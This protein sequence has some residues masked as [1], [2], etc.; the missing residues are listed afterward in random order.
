MSNLIAIGQKYDRLATISGFSTSPDGYSWTTSSRN[1]L[2]FIPFVPRQSGIGIR[3]TKDLPWTVRQYSVFGNLNS[4]VWGNLQYVAVGDNGTIIS[5]SEGVY[6]G[7]LGSGTIHNL[8]GIAFD[9]VTTYVAV[10]DNG[11]VLVST[12]GI[13]W[14]PGTSGI[15][16]QLLAI[17]WSS[18]L[19][20]FIA[21]GVDGII[22]SSPNGLSWTTQISGTSLQLNTIACIP[23]VWSVGGWDSSLPPWS[24]SYMIAAGENGIILTSQDGITW[25][26]QTSGIT[27]SINSVSWDG[28]GVIAV[29]DNGVF[30]ASEDSITW[31]NGASGVLNQLNGVCAG[32]YVGVMVGNDGT[33]LRTTDDISA[34]QDESQVTTELYDVTYSI[35]LNLFV[36]VG[37]SGMIMTSSIENPTQTFTAVSDAGY[38]TSS[39]DGNVWS[40]GSIIKANFSPRAVEQGLDA[41]GLNI[42][43]MV[44][45]TQKYAED[46]LSNSSLNEVAQIFVSSNATGMISVDNPGF[47]DSWVMVY[48]EDSPNSIYHGVRHIIPD[49]VTVTTAPASNSSITST[50]FIN[51]TANNPLMQLV[52]L[53]GANSISDVGT[54]TFSTLPNTALP[55][56]NVTVTDTTWAF[57]FTG[58]ASFTID[59]TAIFNFTHPEVWVVA[60]EADNNPILRYS[61]DTGESWNQVQIPSLFN[62]LALFDITYVNDQ[63][64]ISGYGVVIYTYSII[65]PNWNASDFVTSPYG[66]PN[67]IKI[68]SNPSGH[69]VAA[70]SGMLF[71]TTDGEVW[72]SYYQPGYQFVSIIWYIDHW[73][74]GVSSLLTRYT[75]FTS[76]DTINWIGANNSI[77]MYDFA[78][79]P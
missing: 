9:G 41:N 69:V 74:A 60:G 44:V 25:I 47:E 27:T 66:N 17:A 30:I 43:L 73:V 23:A 63:F 18:D 65:N 34:T 55:L 21:V 64:Y 61:L 57:G 2:P 71:Y 46:E 11:V 16:N 68:A 42:S 49:P 32:Q 29:G 35:Y 40:D 22:L 8:N 56:T 58:T 45:G 19:N 67:M 36:A 13:N 75:Y 72:A 12:N 20:L 6:W 33:I 37:Q 28:Y 79:I 14:G 24:Y 53:L 1:D 5:S 52:D 39:F 3:W 15:L 7:I 77:Q 38:I 4:V 54:V 76:T 48:A 59:D 51:I 26:P 50:V 62:G 70:A 31:T 78:I 10:G